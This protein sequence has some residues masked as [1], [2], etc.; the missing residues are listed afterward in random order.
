MLVGQEIA[1]GRK[2]YH[3]HFEVLTSEHKD[4][5]HVQCVNGRCSVLPLEEFEVLPPTEVP[6]GAKRQKLDN[7]PPIPVCIFIVTVFT[8]LTW[9]GCHFFTLP[10]FYLFRFS[11]FLYN[12]CLCSDQRACYLR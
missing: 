12:N 1:G 2:K 4:V 9:T 5:V 11:L 6:C 3:G 10:C 8:G 7:P